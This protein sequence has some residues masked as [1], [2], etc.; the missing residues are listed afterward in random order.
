MKDFLKEL[1]AYLAN[2][3]TDK[4][5]E[6]W[7]KTEE[8]D[9]VGIRADQF[10]ISTG[11]YNFCSSPPDFVKIDANLNPEYTS[12]FFLNDNWVCNERSSIFTLRL[13]I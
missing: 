13:Q 7:A 8:W 4:I 1:E 3:P 5:L 10:L 2:T 6:D 11:N 9:L 12:G